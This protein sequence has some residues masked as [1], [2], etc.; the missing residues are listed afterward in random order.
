MLI[1]KKILK[2]VAVL[3]RGWSKIECALSLSQSFFGVRSK[4]FS[5]TI[6]QSQQNAWG[7]GGLRNWLASHQG[8]VVMLLVASCYTNQGLSEPSDSSKSF[9]VLQTTNRAKRKL[10]AKWLNT[11]SLRR[12]PIPILYDWLQLLPPCRKVYH[13]P[14]NMNYHPSVH[15]QTFYPSIRLFVYGSL[16]LSLLISQPASQW[17]WVSHLQL[18]GSL[19]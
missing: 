9:Y 3:W 15:P 14:T 16:F 5:W 7:R 11:C 13:W 18:T 12:I 17:S 6:R 2:V 19:I 4:L 10:Q 1:R 8:V